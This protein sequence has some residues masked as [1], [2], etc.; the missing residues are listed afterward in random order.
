MEIMLIYIIIVLLLIC[1]GMKI[2]EENTFHKGYL[3][4]RTTTAVNGIFVIL[5]FF[6]HCTEALKLNGALDSVYVTMKDSLLQMVVVPFLFYSGY[7][8]MESIKKKDGYVN[9]IP[10]HRLLKVLVHFDIAVVLFVITGLLTGRTYELKQVLLAF[11]GWTSVG[12][13]NWYIFVILILYL[14]VYFAFKV[15]GRKNTILYN[16]LSVL[17]TS[18]LVLAYI[19][20]MMQWEIPTRFYNTILLFPV[21][22]FYSL[23]RNKIEKI[24]MKNDACYVGACVITFVLYYWFY[25]HKKE[26][27]SYYILW[28]MAFMMLVL[29]FTMKIQLQNTFLLWFGK[30]V[31]GIYILQRI[32]MNIL[33]YFRGG[34][35]VERTYVF[36]LSCFLATIFL[37]VIF[38]YVLEKVDKRMFGNK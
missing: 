31:F 30:N 33:K 20:L 24:C 10:R 5:V 38:N 17:G 14:I 16:L 26:H 15:L 37:T 18:V 35:Y 23:F 21:G 4:K 9:K 6:S 13:S 11:I 32:P 29:L 12:N 27:I 1:N 7:G 34:I 25:C 22:M 36:I 8:I 19:L 3:D 2:A 28:G